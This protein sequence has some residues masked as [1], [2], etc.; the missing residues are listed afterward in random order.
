[1]AT[2]G[3]FKTGSPITVSIQAP[4]PD[5]PC[6]LQIVGVVSRK[7]HGS[8]GDFD[9]NLP[10]S[11]SPGI[12]CRSSAGNHTFVFTFTNEVVSGNVTVTAGTGSVSGPPIFSG[13][14]MTVALSGVADGQ[15][16]TVMAAGVTDSFGQT[17]PDTFVMASL[18]AGDVNQNRAVNSSDIS[19]TKS[20]LGQTLTSSNFTADINANGGINAADVSIV[21]ANLG[22]ALP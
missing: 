22:H 20:Q 16:I 19:A 13:N 8:A 9:I 18:L 5:V 3:F 12:E 4:T 11:G 10:L 2:V 15:N 17:L 14:T 21:K 6:A 7:T 1:M